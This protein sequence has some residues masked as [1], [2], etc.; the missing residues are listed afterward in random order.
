[1]IFSRAFWVS[2]IVGVGLAGALS[3]CTTKKESAAAVAA[4]CYWLS[5]EGAG[6]VARPDV[7]EKELCF[8]MDSCSGGVGM[9]GGG[10]YKWATGPDAPAVSWGELGL[11]QPE[12]ARIDADPAAAAQDSWYTTA[13]AGAA[14]CY[15]K[16]GDKWTYDRYSTREAQCF[17]R[18][19]CSGGLGQGG[20]DGEKPCFK[21]AMGPDAPALGWSAA[22]TNPQLAADIPPPDEAREATFEQTSDDCFGPD[23]NLGAMRVVA[24]TPI[25]ARP[26]PAA[27]LV[28]RIAAGECVLI[29]TSSLLQ[30][31]VRGVVLESFGAFSAGDVIYS[32]AYEGEG[33]ESI[34]RRGETLSIGGS[35]APV[36]RWDPP[37]T[38]PDPR[39]GWWLWLK[40]ANGQSGWA[41]KND[42]DKDTCT[43]ASR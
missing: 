2:L 27:P 3:A 5:N 24:A 35:E 39:E 31:P 28:A 42:A 10:C 9:S 21:W 4:Q 40:R 12:A 18:D 8:E 37:R 41:K 13:P 1:M 17:Q 14:A 29:K 22:L 16:H 19:H 23:C 33:S 26:D 32:L 38:S 43:F 36:V 7:P 20:R 25:R 11:A 15:E 30:L 34:W 6:W